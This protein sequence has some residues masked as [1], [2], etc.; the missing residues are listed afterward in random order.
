MHGIISEEGSKFRWVCREVERDILPY[1]RT[2]LNDK[3][4]GL[5]LAW[6]DEIPLYW[7]P[8]VLGADEGPG[9]Q[10]QWKRLIM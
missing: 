2:R 9:K 1:L 7:P 3:A 8:A 6:R 10:K 4:D 5:F